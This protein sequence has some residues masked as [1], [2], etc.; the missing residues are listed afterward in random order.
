[1]Y[2]QLFPYSRE[3]ECGSQ[4]IDCG[5]MNQELDFFLSRLRITKTDNHLDSIGIRYKGPVLTGEMSVGVKFQLDQLQ[6]ARHAARVEAQLRSM[7][8]RCCAGPTLT[9]KK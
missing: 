3:K 2:S 4:A 8:G 6:A 1:L 7:I 9:T 5:C